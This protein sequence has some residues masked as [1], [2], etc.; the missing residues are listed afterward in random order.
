MRP[1]A[2][3]RSMKFEELYLKDFYS[4]NCT[5]VHYFRSILQLV[6]YYWGAIP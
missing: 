3:N 6:L 1:K 4:E 2:I 5:K